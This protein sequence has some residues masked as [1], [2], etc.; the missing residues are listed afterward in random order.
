M[1]NG[2]AQFVLGLPETG[3]GIRD[4]IFHESIVTDAISHL[5]TLFVVGADWKPALEDQ[6]LP[7]LFRILA[8]MVL[9]HQATQ[10]LFI[11]DD[12]YLINLLLDLEGIPTAA[13]IGDFATLILTNAG[14]QP[15]ACADDITRLKQGRLDALRKRAEMARTQ[16]LEAASEPLPAAFLSML[17]DLREEAWECCICKEGYSAQPNDLLG[18][19]VFVSR[20]S[21]VIS[22]ATYFVCVH[23]SCHQQAAG[24]QR[25]NR[26]SEWDAA[27]VRNCE[28]PCNAIF[29]LPS[30]S[31]NFGKY[32]TAL[33]RFLDEARGRVSIDHFQLL[34]QNL[35]HQI[36]VVAAGGRIPLSAGGGSLASILSFVPFLVYAGH[37]VLQD[38]DA[39]KG[40][41]GKVE[42]VLEGGEA[43]EEAMVLGL[44]AMS[45]VEWLEV[46][47]GLLRRLVKSKGK[48]E[49]NLWEG[50]KEQFFFFML[51]DRMQ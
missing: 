43:V 47:V 8:G 31:M 40:L 38:G 34:V 17:D 15:S 24:N 37:V 4:L 35:R 44:W 29:P 41:E 21:A 1:L 18:V 28:R 51:L 7:M 36:Q 26:G 50:V 49:E 46:R 32:R 33:T 27:S 14:K 42:A 39:R 45:L 9:C 30:E 3:G 20:T 16:A 25:G 2:F 10:L 12:C 23:P 5:K 13:A 19:Y 22:I 6:V 11:A 48:R